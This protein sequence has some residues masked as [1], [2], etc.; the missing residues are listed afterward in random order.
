MHLSEAKKKSII[1]KWVENH[2]T[3]VICPG[4]NEVIREDEDLK[5]VEYVRTKILKVLSM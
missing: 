4:C 5:G 2:K 3:P 1:E